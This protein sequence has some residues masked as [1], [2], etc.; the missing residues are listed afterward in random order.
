MESR[1]GLIPPTAQNRRAN[2]SL[3]YDPFRSPGSFGAFAGFH[4]STNTPKLQAR[5]LHQLIPTQICIDSPRLHVPWWAL[6]SRS[7]GNRVPSSSCKR[8]CLLD[9]N[10]HAEGR[11]MLRDNPAGYRT[12]KPTNPEAIAPKSPDASS[13]R[14]SC[15]GPRHTDC[16]QIAQRLSALSVAPFSAVCASLRAPEPC[17]RRSAKF[18]N[19]ACLF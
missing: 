11:T 6:C 19:Q 9:P 14:C 1:L 10:Q 5:M 8:L 16:H 17:G 18:W 15:A 4:A 3:G 12:A 7:R 13:I 2:R